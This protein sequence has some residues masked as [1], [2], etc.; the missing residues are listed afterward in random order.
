M[1]AGVVEALN[2]VVVREVPDSVVTPG[3]V[4]VK[5]HAC[6]VCGS[7]IR[8]FTQGDP[9]AQLPQIIGH[10]I[11]GEIVEV[12]AAVSTK[13]HVGQRVCVAPIHGCNRCVYCRRGKGN[14]CINPQPSIG[15]ASSGGFAQY[16]VPPESV[17][18]AGGVNSIPDNVTY[19]E[20][21]MSEL[22]ATCINAQEKLRI[23]SNDTVLIMGAGPAGCMHAQLARSKGANKIIMTQ[24][25]TARLELCKRF[26]P[27][28]VINSV[29]ESLCDRVKEETDGLGANVIIVAA[30]SAEAQE[31]ALDLVAPAG[32]ISF[33]GGLPKGHHMIT[34]SGN[35]I[36]YRECE[37]FGASSSL[38][39][40]NREALSLIS[41]GAIHARDYITHRF[42]LDD[43]GEAFRTVQEK[44][45]LKVVVFPWGVESGFESSVSGNGQSS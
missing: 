42:A 17:V 43:I 37:I 10:E 20:A 5:V 40:Q 28:V 12:G 18:D 31:H 26:D 35:T 1:K 14:L 21:A 38:G 36:H 19:A 9:R 6:A 24:R 44:L 34:I 29:E 7:D 27:D 8:I 22:L 23:T 4:K 2:K 41:S 15:Y 32:R 25:S 13:F 39:R 16:I 11:A 30:P 33:F 3:S 45:G